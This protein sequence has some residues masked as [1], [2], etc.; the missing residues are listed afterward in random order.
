M[1]AS[2]RFGKDQSDM[3][4]HQCFRRR[5]AEVAVGA[6]VLTIA[7]V[8]PAIPQTNR[9]SSGVRALDIR[10]VQPV[11]VMT[12]EN[13]F[14]VIVKGSDGN[15]IS[16]ADVSLSFVMSAW[17]VRRIPET[18]RALRLKS[19]SDGRYTGSWK[20]EMAGDWVTT[21]RVTKNG[22][23]IGRTALILTAP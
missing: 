19:S 12:G 18:R 10:L 20:F 22:K 15:A 9:N 23:E 5:V 13:P 4:L 3:S 1:R 16:D 17:P 11:H 2:D 7:A 14:E 21:I 6:V 8:G